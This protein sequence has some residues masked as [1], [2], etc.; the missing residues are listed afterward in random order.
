MRV[1]VLKAI[2]NIYTHILNTYI[3]YIYIKF[4]IPKTMFGLLH[5]LYQNT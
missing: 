4:S 2:I 3:K 5:E 1:L